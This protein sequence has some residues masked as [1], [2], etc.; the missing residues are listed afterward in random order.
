MTDS[1]H[2]CGPARSESSQLARD[3]RAF[4]RRAGQ[5][6]ATTP[7][8]PPLGV[9]R[10]RLRLIAEEFGELLEACG[11]R[12]MDVAD[13]ER[14]IATA[15]QLRVDHVSLVEVAD[16]LAD[17][18]YVIVGSDA[19][20]GIDGDAVDREVAR[21]N[22]SKF[23]TTVRADGKV[24]KAPHYSP[25]DIAGVLGISDGNDSE[26]PKGSVGL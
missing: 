15:V 13:V 17:L 18:R 5:H 22:A 21:S 4:M 9:L 1:L 23:P 25:P 10:L 20:F 12:P 11:C 19:A 3:V 14:A 6:I 24:M 26:S 7:T 16:A 8:V 2:D